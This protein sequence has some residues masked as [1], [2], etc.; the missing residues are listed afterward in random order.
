MLFSSVQIAGPRQVSKG[1]VTALTCNITNCFSSRLGV[2]DHDVL[3]RDASSDWVWDTHWHE[4]E[5]LLFPMITLTHE[6]INLLPSKHMGTEVFLSNAA[7]REVLAAGVSWHRPDA[8]ISGCPSTRDSSLTSSSATYPPSYRSTAVPDRR[9]HITW[10]ILLYTN[11]LYPRGQ[12][13]TTC[14]C[15]QRSRFGDTPTLPS[16]QLQ[17]RRVWFQRSLHPIS[18]KHAEVNPLPPSFCESELDVFFNEW[19]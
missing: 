7:P 4:R 6:F 2:P 14:F 9:R 13:Y 11:M 5:R 3:Q 12:M 18:N 16:G 8:L 19:F 10:R 1:L 17:C 15:L